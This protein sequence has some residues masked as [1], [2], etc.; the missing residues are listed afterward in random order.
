MTSKAARGPIPARLPVFAAPMMLISG[1]ALVTAAC[2]A[3]IIGAFPSHNARTPADLEQW[4]Q[5]ITASLAE[6]RREDPARLI[7]PWCVNLVTHSTN[8]RLPQDLALVGR[9]RPPIVVTA[10]GSP[11]PVI[12]VVHGYGGIVI[13]D[14]ISMT[15]ARKAIAAGAD[16]LA[17]ISAGAG[18]HTGFLSPFAFIAAVRA[19]FDGLIVV[20]GGISD[21]HGVAGAIAAGAD[22]VYMGTR[23]IPTVESMA[24]PQY[25]QMIVDSGIDDL[26][27]SAAIS[28]TA[29]SWLKPSLRAAGLDPDALTDTPGRSYDTTKERPTRWRDI[30]AA[31]QGIGASKSVQPVADIVD[32]LEREYRQTLAMMAARV[33]FADQGKT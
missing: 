26:V 14:V 16:G 15:L 1:V 23:F 7:A 20:G 33:G 5:Q 32:E 3:G 19:I 12:E 21:G 28:G 31:G 27:V 8:A 25:K 9:Y 22:F 6:A 29:A 24:V 18:G 10:L 13:A 2:R 17:C 4:M 11:K 30:W